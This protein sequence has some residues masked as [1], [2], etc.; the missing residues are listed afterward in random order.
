M[1]VSTGVFP[2]RWKQANIIPLYKKGDKKDPAD[3]RSVSL[4]PL[5]GKVLERVVNDELF[6]HVKSVL[7][8]HQHGFIPGRSCVA[9]LSIYLKYAWEAIS[10]G[11]Q[12]DAIY[13]DYSAAFQSVNDALLIHKLKNSYHLKE[14]ALDWFAS[15]LSD[16]RQRVIVNGKASV[17]E[18][19]G[20]PEGSLLAPSFFRCSSTTYRTTLRPVAF[21]KP[22]MS[23]LFS[24]LPPQLTDCR[25][26][27]ISANCVRG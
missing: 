19:S 23:K 1:S 18:T 20:V 2:E 11:Y 13:T 22:T 3:Y 24:K 27:R 21:C 4:L 10:D 26:R 7:S 25:C 14:L 16:R 5:F 8:Q 12:T 15:Y 17:V 6:R 9:N